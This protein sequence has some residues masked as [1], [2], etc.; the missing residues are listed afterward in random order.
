MSE[1]FRWDIGIDGEP[2]LLNNPTKP[3]TT[4]NSIKG[5]W[6]IGNGYAYDGFA[7][8]QLFG[9]FAESNSLTEIRIP[10]TVKK[11]SRQAFKNTQL[12]SVTI[13][14]D[15]EYYDTSFPE[16]CVVNYY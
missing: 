13:A 2:C 12:T 11:I 16:G 10:P 7:P 5:A 14:R 3:D 6:H 9:A 4:Y 8:P 15:C 1:E